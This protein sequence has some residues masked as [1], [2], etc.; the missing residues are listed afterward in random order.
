MKSCV[1]LFLISCIFYHESTNEQCLLIHTVL[2]LARGLGLAARA[3]ACKWT[4]WLSP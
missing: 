4:R 3:H 2:C 1:G